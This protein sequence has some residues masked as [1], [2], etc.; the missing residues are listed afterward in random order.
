MKLAVQ[1]WF[2]NYKR[3]VWP[4]IKTSSHLHFNHL[5]RNSYAWAVTIRILQ[6]NDISIPSSIFAEKFHFSVLIRIYTQHYERLLIA[7]FSLLQFVQ[8]NN[9]ARSAPRLLAYFLKSLIFA[10]RDICSIDGWLKK[11]GRTK[12]KT[13][14][15][16]RR[17]YTWFYGSGLSGFFAISRS[18]SL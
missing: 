12:I 7:Q 18:T 13:E 4:F 6:C 10:R 1:L 2:N 5:L 9:C 3:I 11:T 14:T 16:Q 17:C 8:R 15:S